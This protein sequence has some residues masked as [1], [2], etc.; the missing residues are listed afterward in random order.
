MDEERAFVKKALAA[1]LILTNLA[2]LDVPSSRV[3]RR[4]RLSCSSRNHSV[5]TKNFSHRWFARACPGLHVDTMRHPKMSVE[6]SR[7]CKDA[8][9]ATT[10]LLSLF[11]TNLTSPVPDEGMS[12]LN[13]LINVVLAVEEAATI[14]VWTR[15]ILLRSIMI[16]GYRV[17][18]WLS[19]S[20]V[21][22]EVSCAEGRSPIVVLH[23]SLLRWCLVFWCGQGF[24]NDVL[25]LRWEGAVFWILTA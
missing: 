8:C 15:H 22:V 3:H 13:M 14:L 11:C 2:H 25:L 21:H 24:L 23:R 12:L 10:P 4:C 18:G 7:S 5:D 20:A 9:R 16:A 6:R 1:T 17:L 19:I